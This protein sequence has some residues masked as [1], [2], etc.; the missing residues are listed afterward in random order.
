MPSSS[1]ALN[2]LQNTGLKTAQPY[3]TYYG[4][5]NWAPGTDAQLG[6]TGAG[7]LPSLALFWHTDQPEI[8]MPTH[9]HPW[10]GM[11]VSCVRTCKEEQNEIDRVR[12]LADAVFS[13][14]LSR[15]WD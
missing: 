14:E 12:R 6:G 10:G 2:A 4:G 5:A 13:L 9:G 15:L 1:A 11:S 3:N 7:M 8:H